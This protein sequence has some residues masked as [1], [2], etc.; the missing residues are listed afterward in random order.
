MN[1]TTDLA[2]RLLAALL[3]F[4]SGNHRSEGVRRIA[5]HQ[6][7]TVAHLEEAVAAHPTVPAALLISVGF[8]ET[9]LGY[10]DGEGGCWGSPIDRFH[11]HVSGG[12]VAASRDLARSFEVCHDWLHATHRYRVGLCNGTE[13]GGYSAEQALQLAERLLQAI[14]E[15]LPVSWRHP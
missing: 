9:H 15:P 1:P 7:E 13:H 14:G 3:S 10:D 8:Y 6:A 2:A 11:R 4:Y 12:P 5:A